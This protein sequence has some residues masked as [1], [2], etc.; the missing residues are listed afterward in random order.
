MACAV[1]RVGDSKSPEWGKGQ[2]NSSADSCFH[3]A[4]NKHASL[5]TETH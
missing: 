2:I 1:I 5:I 3:P 4:Q